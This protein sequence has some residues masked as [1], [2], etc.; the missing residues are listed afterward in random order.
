T[1]MKHPRKETLF[2][3]LAGLSLAMLACTCGPLSQVTGVAATI[4]AA[5][6]G[7]NELATEAGTMLTEAAPTLDALTTQA[8]NM[9]PTLTAMAGQLPSMGADGSLRQ[10]AIA[11]TASSEYGSDSWSAMQATGAP[12]TLECGDITTA[13]ASGS[14]SGVDDLTLTYAVPVTATGIEI[15]QTYNPGSIVRVEV[16]DLNGAATEVYSAQ[17]AASAACPEVLQIAVQN[18]PTVNTVKIYLDQ[19]VIGSWNEI[20]AVELI[21]NP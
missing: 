5:A 17:P 20:D 10:W 6:T 19:S 15:H 18:V 13:W 8:A 11:A 2:M 7:V 4:E 21:G 16:I 1:L 9:E 3:A 14:G 12:N